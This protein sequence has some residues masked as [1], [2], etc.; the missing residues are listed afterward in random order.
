MKVSRYIILC[1][2]FLKL[3]CKEN[4]KENNNIKHISAEEMQSILDLEEVQL[5]D[6]RTKAEFEESHILN[7]QNID[8]NSPTF[9][10]DIKKL[11]KD[12][13]VI[14]YCNKGGRSAECAKQLQYAGFKKIYDLEGGISKW[15]HSNHLKLKKSSY[16]H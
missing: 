2:I 8:F 5:V 1:F 7:S 9:N 13:P 11:K 4:S 3:S 6:V 12:K 14:L 10:E 16:N 15:K